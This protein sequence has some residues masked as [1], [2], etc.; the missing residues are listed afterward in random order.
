M[1]DRP[2]DIPGQ[3]EI[4]AL[5]RAGAVP[6]RSGRSLIP[7]PRTGHGPFVTLAPRPAPT[8]RHQRQKHAH[9]THRYLWIFR[10]PRKQ[11]RASP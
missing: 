5:Y 6:L 1:L 4:M 9:K 2:A 8:R 3:P 10:K 11:A 7:P